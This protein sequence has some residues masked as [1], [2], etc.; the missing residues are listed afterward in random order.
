MEIHIYNAL[1]TA[2]L[3]LN[4]CPQLMST[5][6]SLTQGVL[7]EQRNS[8]DWGLNINDWYEARDKLSGPLKEH[9]G[10][11]LK[12]HPDWLIHDLAGECLGREIDLDTWNGMSREEQDE[13][14][15]NR[16]ARIERD[17]WKGL[18]TDDLEIV[19]AE[20]ADWLLM[21]AVH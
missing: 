15:E 6:T 17:A 7:D 19:W 20:L 9:L 21:E 10:D 8:E 5:A 1:D 3:N 11:H 12:N 14:W 18:S 13:V 4:A 16:A 2:L